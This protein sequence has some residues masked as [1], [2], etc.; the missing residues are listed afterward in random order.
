MTC[1][2]SR[3]P[4][5]FWLSVMATAGCESAPAKVAIFSIRNI[6]SAKE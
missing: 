2:N 3:A 4:N 1:E 6:D 5:M